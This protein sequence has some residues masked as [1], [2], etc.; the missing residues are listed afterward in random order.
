MVTTVALTTS[1]LKD[2]KI[3][4]T[5]NSQ[6]I[7]SRADLEALNIPGKSGFFWGSN[8]SIWDTLVETQ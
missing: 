7:I 8:S 2:V 4:P 5:D 6:I 1:H 3:T